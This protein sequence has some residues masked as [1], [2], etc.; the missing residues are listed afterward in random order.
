MNR[1]GGFSRLHELMERSRSLR[2]RRVQTQELPAARRA[3]AEWQSQR[4][5]HTY[6]DFAA[7]PRYRP[8]VDFFLDD[9]YGPVDFTQRDADI[10]RVYPV[11]AR[12][13][14][15][16]A[17]ATIDAALELH[18]LSAE[19]DARMVEILT[20]ELGMTDRLDEQTYA[21]AFR[22]CGERASRERQVELIVELGRTLDAVVHHPV[23]YATLLAARLPARLAGFGELQDFLERGVRAFRHMRGADKFI[24]AVEEREGRMIELMFAD[25]EPSDRSA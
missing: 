24:A 9:L 3:L 5:A 2:R 19:L 18:A 25:A 10:E 12:V 14:S 20:G 7:Q 8:A 21:E 1:R 6:A 16:Q 17:L 11:M 4:L 23:T 22:R 15:G 13:L